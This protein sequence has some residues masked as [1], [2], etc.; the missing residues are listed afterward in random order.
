[1]TTPFLSLIV[2]FTSAAP[3]RPLRHHV[4]GVPGRPGRAVFAPH[5][6]IVL[7]VRHRGTDQCEGRDR[8]HTA[9]P[10]AAAASVSTGFTMRPPSAS[11]STYRGRPS[12]PARESGPRPGHRRRIAPTAPGRRSRPAADTPPIVLHTPGSN[13]RANGPPDAELPRITKTRI[14]RLV[15]AGPAA[16]WM[17]AVAA[18]LAKIV[19]VWLL[20]NEWKVPGNREVSARRGVC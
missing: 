13:G 18:P 17:P 15:P 9:A 11:A 5:P 7:A 10:A 4:R 2:L 16:A 1:M 19:R 20:Q 8:A 3:S 6:L 12:P 14:T